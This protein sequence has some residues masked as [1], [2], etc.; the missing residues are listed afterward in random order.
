M[1]K[2]LFDLFIYLRYKDYIDIELLE[3]FGDNY[4]KNPHAYK[5]YKLKLINK[6]RKTQNLKTDDVVK[7]SKDVLF[8]QLNYED[9]NTI[10]QKLNPGDMLII[11]DIDSTDNP[12]PYIS[13]YKGPSLAKKL[14]Q[15]DIKE[16][17]KT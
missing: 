7:P 12:I 17:D 3:K 6:Y 8:K 1:L 2:K 4:A 9:I 10:K 14:I 13:I 16:D 5:V 11:K 15:N